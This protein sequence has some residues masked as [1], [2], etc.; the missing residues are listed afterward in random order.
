MWISQLTFRYW[1]NLQVSIFLKSGKLKV[2]CY[3]GLVEQASCLFL[4]VRQE[5]LT[6]LSF[7]KDM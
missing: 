7:L 4:L 1:R 2:F 5:C 3:I 6:Y